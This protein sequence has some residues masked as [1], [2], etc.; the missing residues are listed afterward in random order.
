MSVCINILTDMGTGPSPVFPLSTFSADQWS[1]KDHCEL[2]AW[3]DVV[4]PLHSNWYLHQS[5]ISRIALHE[6][7]VCCY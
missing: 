7:R 2:L 1:L 5:K 4:P 6:I 3:V